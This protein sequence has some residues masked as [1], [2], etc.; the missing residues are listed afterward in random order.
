MTV[1]TVLKREEEQCLTCEWLRIE[2]E[3]RASG[4]NGKVGDKEHKNDWC[5][6]FE[7]AP[8]GMCVGWVRTERRR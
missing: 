3:R 1:G 7:T 5:E 2:K 6:M 4:E 8:M